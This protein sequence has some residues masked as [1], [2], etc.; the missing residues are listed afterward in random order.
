MT[1]PKVIEEYR[2]HKLEVPLN[3]P[4]IDETEFFQQ[5]LPDT[6]KT[7]VNHVVRVVRG[8][9]EY[10]LSD[11]TMTGQTL[12]GN[13]RYLNKQFG[14]Y[15]FPYF[16][17]AYDDVTGTPKANGRID[18]YELRY[19]IESSPKAIKALLGKDQMGTNTSMTIDFG[20]GLQYPVA[21][22]N[23]FISMPADKLI[24]KI[25]G[26]SVETITGAPSQ[27]VTSE[28]DTSGRQ[29]TNTQMEQEEAR[30]KMYDFSF[31]G[32]S[33]SSF[34]PTEEQQDAAAQTL[35]PQPVLDVKPS[36]PTPS[37]NTDETPE[38]E[39][40]KMEQK[41]GDGEKKAVGQS[42]ATNRVGENVGVVLKNEDTGVK[43]NMTKD[44]ITIEEPQGQAAKK[45]RDRDSEESEEAEQKRKR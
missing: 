19:D 13:R 21:N 24:S 31:I 32:N 15:Q 22:K 30:R 3:A 9:K 14:K 25:T 7:A 44:S 42:R 33:S 16:V 5:T 10:L 37:P 18:R 8:D 12:E 23:D 40:V 11:E 36:T 20:E 39:Q 1:H 35:V 29:L 43:Q 4:D 45:Q 6:R 38:Q 28:S 41:D 2:K 17:M 34:G 27:F 26:K